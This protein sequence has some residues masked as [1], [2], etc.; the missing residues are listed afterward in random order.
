MHPITSSVTPLETEF[1]TSVNPHL[2]A[3]SYRFAASALHTDYC[4]CLRKALA[5]AS[6]S[7]VS[8]LPL[9][10]GAFK[11][12]YAKYK[13]TDPD[14]RSRAFLLKAAGQDV[15][16]QKR[17]YYPKLMFEAKQVAVWQDIDQDNVGGVFQSGSDSYGSSRIKLELD[18]PLIDLTL[19]HKVGEAKAVERYHEGML[20]VTEEQ[21]TERF[22]LVF[23][24]AV[25]FGHLEDSIDRVIARLEKELASA[26]ESFEE[27]MATVE[28]VEN[29]KL[30]LV[31]MRQEKLLMREQ[32]RRSLAQ[33]ALGPDTI[34]N[35]KLSDQS[36]LQLPRPVGSQGVYFP[37]GTTAQAEID[38][39]DS[40][41][42]A[43]QGVDAPRLGL[44]GLVQHDDAGGSQFGT[45]RTLNGY[46]VGLVLR[47]NFFDSGVNQSEAQRLAYLKQAKEAELEALKAFNDRK[48]DFAEQSVKLSQSNLRSL[49]NLVR[50]QSSI[51]KAVELA[52][53]EGGEKTYISMINAFMIY[54][55]QVRQRI[56][57]RFDYI[58]NQTDLYASHTGWSSGLI[59]DLDR[60]F[61]AGR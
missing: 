17:G 16:T 27:R 55:S 38:A 47:W 57:G 23:L 56:Q 48:F 33:L 9:S 18:Q 54:E 52:Y 53:E 8:A 4:G 34:A 40:R 25:R 58:K 45:E 29:I 44:Y 50:H 30:A 1:G 12:A 42:R 2:R 15:I 24:E 37:R 26:S 22:V 14:L 5:V 3:G 49:D 21:L 59:E 7:L 11:D 39:L 60:M 13:S 41:I 10:A 6:F 20:Q 61:V 28:D 35:L 46:E 19:K 32:Q 36:N 43:T 31:A 51:L